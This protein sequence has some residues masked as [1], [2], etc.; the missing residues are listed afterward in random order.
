M[1]QQH[2][3]SKCFFSNTISKNSNTIAHVR[4]QLKFKMFMYLYSKT[5]KTP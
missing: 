1:Q 5:P 2:F 4:T 3:F